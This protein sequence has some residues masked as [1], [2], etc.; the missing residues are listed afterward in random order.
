VPRINAG[1]ASTAVRAIMRRTGVTFASGA[2]NPW[3]Y[4]AAEVA[5]ATPA[6]LWLTVA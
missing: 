2:P 4:N 3:T 1:A 5:T 6:A